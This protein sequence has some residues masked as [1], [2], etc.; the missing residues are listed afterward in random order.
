MAKRFA[1]QSRRLTPWTT[2]ILLG[3]A[4]C[5][6]A[7]AE[8]RIGP[9]QGSLVIVGGGG[10]GKEDVIP[11][12]FIELAGGPDAEIVV[13]PTANAGEEFD[14]D[15]GGAKML[16]AAG[17][18]NV[19]LIH[20]R[21]RAVAD[22][23]EF[24]RPLRTARGVWFGG[25]RQWRLADAYLGTRTQKE[26]EGVL[27]RGGVVGG[28][29]AGATIQGSYLVRGAVEGNTVMMSPGHETGFGLLRN[30]AIDQHVIARK[31]TGDLL[32][33]IE[34]HPHLLGIGIDEATAIV[35]QGDT[36]EV[37]GD[38]DVVITDLQRMPADGEEKWYFLKPG[39]R[40]DLATRRKI[41]RPTAQTAAPSIG[42]LDWL[43]I[44]DRYRIG[45]DTSETPD[46]KPWVDEKLK[47]VCATWY[48]KIVDLLP[49]EGFH[50]PETFTITFHEDM[51]G[52]AHC[53]GTSIHC[54]ARWYRQQLDREGLGSIVHEMVHV[55]QQYG[56]HRG[57][58]N[59]GWLVEGLA[60]YIRWHL[61]EPASA[62]R[63]I[64]PARAKY[65][66]SYHV[67][68]AFLAWLVETK[69][70]EVIPRLNA[71]MRQGTFQPES[72][73]SIAGAGVDTLWADYVKTLGPR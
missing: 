4:V 7:F 21:D 52:V 56:R 36:F 32:P 39:E 23:E 12:R 29:S 16:R 9:P 2:A 67:T 1:A 24:V 40:F 13:V 27:A 43:T 48:P 57:Q 38:S 20:T 44:G 10:G 49:S 66:D 18:K 15:A 58:R 26:V 70:P 42:K 45:F 65:T 3:I 19:T 31:R 59:P 54:A 11:R 55:V 53:R 60:D 6:P 68:G 41:E 5:S 35:V 71:A 14:Q 73:E 25:G 8:V 37:I 33:V 17:A 22:S 69:G 34:K 64:D 50:A 46:L 30:C 51:E 63:K 28:S 62:R 47:P 72:W 61:Y